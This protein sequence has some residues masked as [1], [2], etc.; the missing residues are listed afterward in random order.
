M[1]TC[2]VAPRTADFTHLMSPNLQEAVAYA[3]GPDRAQ[4]RRRARPLSIPSAIAIASA[5]SQT[6]GG[7]SPVCAAFFVVRMLGRKVSRPVQAFSTTS[8]KCRGGKEREMRCHDPFSGAGPHELARAIGAPATA[9]EMGRRYG[10]RVR[11]AHSSAR[12]GRVVLRAGV[13]H[14]HGAEPDHESVQ[15]SVLPGRSSVSSR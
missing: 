10:A 13:P 3:D 9:H 7:A 2:C 4:P 14:W 8:S 5:I 12:R 11:A 6:S 1:P 15:F